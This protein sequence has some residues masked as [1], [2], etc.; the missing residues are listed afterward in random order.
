MAFFIGATLF[1][2]CGLYMLNPANPVPND[3]E[4]LDIVKEKLKDF[5]IWGNKENNQ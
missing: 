4:N 3:K 2:V 1:L 5:Y